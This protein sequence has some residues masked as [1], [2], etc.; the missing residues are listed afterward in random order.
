MAGGVNSFVVDLVSGAGL[1]ALGAAAGKTPRQRLFIGG[2]F[3][4]GRRARPSAA[5]NAVAAA[6]QQS[7][8]GCLD[9][10]VLDGPDPAQII[11][12][13][14]RDVPLLRAAGRL[15]SVG[16]RH[17][18][19]HADA[20]QSFTVDLHFVPV[21]AIDDLAVSPNRLFVLPPDAAEP[22]V[23]P[24]RQ[25]FVA[26]LLRRLPEAAEPGPAAPG[27]EALARPGVVSVVTE[28]RNA[29]ELSEAL[30]RFAAV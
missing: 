1:R 5:E 28:V 24:A 2:V 18:A 19:A 27:P 11:R 8:F 17:R 7:V 9:T 23:A 15:T 29:A 10:L 4:C 21:N 14:F 30:M 13:A 3:D 26:Q 12:S 20:T 22:C 16:Y 6:L 25:S